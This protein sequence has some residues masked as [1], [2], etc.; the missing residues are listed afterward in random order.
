[1]KS[2]QDLIALVRAL[3]VTEERRE[4]VLLELEDHVFEEMAELEAAGCSREDA[5]RRAFA[6]L[7]PEAVLRKGLAGVNRAFSFGWWDATLAGVKLGV[8]FGGAIWVSWLWAEQSQLLWWR[9][10]DGNGEGTLATAIGAS[11]A[12]F[13]VIGPALAFLAG[14]PDHA[15]E[16]F[17]S[18]TLVPPRDRMGGLFRRF[19]AAS[20]QER[21]E[22]VSRL[23]AQRAD[24]SW[25]A[26]LVV[27]QVVAFLPFAW[28]IPLSEFSEAAF[29]LR[30]RP[31][32]TMGQMGLLLWLWLSVAITGWVVVAR[33][34]QH[35]PR[36]DPERIA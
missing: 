15:L 5:E 32:P 26:M 35:R 13:A 10:Q 31:D 11:A 29:G 19:F 6:S 30:G 3:P 14:L 20:L 18:R 1:M 2:R 7:G 4:V 33:I 23:W 24:F 12:L 36:K 16:R 27:A 25:V 21:L 22:N 8:W 17:R 9:L 28:E 34:L